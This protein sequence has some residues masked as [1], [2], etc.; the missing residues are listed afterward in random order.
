[1]DAL[2]QRVTQQA[3]Q[4]AIRSGITITTGYALKECGRLLK[5][6]PKSRERD[7]LMQLQL[8]L[9]S[10]IRV[11]AP[12]IDM[13][14]LIAARGNTSLESALS[15]CQGLR[16]DIQKLGQRL[17]NAAQ[18]EQRLRDR[19]CRGAARDDADHELVAIINQI[20][21]LLARIEDAVPLISLAITTSG[22]NLS[23]KLSGT[24]SPSRLLQASTFLT[25]ADTRFTS[26]PNVRLQVGPTYLVSLYML[27]AGHSTRAEGNETTWTTVFKKAKVKLW[28]VP[29]N[30]LY[31]LPGEVA[32]SQIHNNDSVPA[33]AKATE[34]GYQ[35]TIV[36]DLDDGLVHEPEECGP[37]PG[38]FDDVQNAGIRDIV[39]VHEVSKASC[40]YPTCRSIA[41]AVLRSFTATKPNS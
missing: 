32:D 4:Y 10:K 6:A 18:E 28:R 26:N 38:P 35:L 40:E 34:Y 21:L 1:M 7:E 29:L 30:Q 12:S 23:T 31:S 2:L 8:R 9:D 11:I 41:N 25:T 22:V 19:G 3:V 14:E 37:T 13:I 16:Y 27:F 20:K 15:L 5:Q 33:E 36:E 24:I 39:P 17:D